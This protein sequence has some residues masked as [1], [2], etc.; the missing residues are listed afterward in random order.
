M[1]LIKE[2]I[3]DLAESEVE[4]VVALG[5][6]E[7]VGQVFGGNIVPD[8]RYDE[9]R[10]PEGERIFGKLPEFFCLISYADAETVIASASKAKWIEMA[11]LI[12]SIRRSTIFSPATKERLEKEMTEEF[13]NRFSSY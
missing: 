7:S 10:S 6:P 4:K 11:D 12:I 3:Y 8:H 5:L 9:F 1:S 2:F 13:Y